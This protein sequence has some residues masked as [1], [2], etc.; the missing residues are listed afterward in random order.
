MLGVICN[1]ALY[2]QLSKNIIFKQSLRFKH[3]S[4]ILWKILMVAHYKSR[5]YSFISVP[6]TYEHK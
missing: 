2:Y 6:T 5:F 1:L 3:L 4:E